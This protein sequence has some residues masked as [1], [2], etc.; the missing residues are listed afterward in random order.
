VFHSDKGTEGS[1]ERPVTI[2][3]TFI[4]Q[5]SETV[6]LECTYMYVCVRVRFTCTQI[7][8]LS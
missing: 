5:S 6:T 4:L 2:L 8:M 7:Y 3:Y 1:P